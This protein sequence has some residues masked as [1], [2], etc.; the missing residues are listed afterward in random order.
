MALLPKG[1]AYR[2]YAG[3]PSAMIFQ[4]LQGPVTIEKWA[5]ICQTGSL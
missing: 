3:A 1:S 5:D 4:T 2:F